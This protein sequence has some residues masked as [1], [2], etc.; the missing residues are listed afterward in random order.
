MA[1]K[2][3]I[4]V[5]MQNDFCPGGS[6]AVP[7]GDE[8]IEP[9]NQLVQEYL[10]AGDLVVYTKDHH[11][12]DHISFQSNHIDGIWPNHCV[13]NTTGWEFHPDLNVEGPVFYKAFLTEEDSYSGFGGHIEANKDAQL[14]ADYLKE[15]GVEAVAVV[16]L[17]L[18]YCVK[19][20]AL[21]ARNLGFDSTV[22]L[23]GTR[24]VNV[25][26]GDGNKAIGEMEI[27]GITVL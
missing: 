26:P 23:K 15:N 4:V 1:K 17:A 24:A 20:T 13:Q 18:D 9:I 3:L 25:H 19:S 5:D 8:V 2:A 16:G 22:L 21:D 14:L 7:N 6:L 11:P 12:V 27:L 10:A